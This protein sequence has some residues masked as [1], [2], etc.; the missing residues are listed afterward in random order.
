MKHKCKIG[1]KD[2]TKVCKK[3]NEK[4]T[5]PICITDFDEGD[6]NM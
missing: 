6:Y 2:I 3:I 5:C 4:I 1:I